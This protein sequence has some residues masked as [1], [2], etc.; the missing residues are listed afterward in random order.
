MKDKVLR[1]MAMIPVTR[2]PLSLS[3]SLLCWNLAV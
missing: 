3:F 1:S 2:L